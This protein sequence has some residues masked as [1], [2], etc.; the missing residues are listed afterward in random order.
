MDGLSKRIDRFRHDERGVAL[1][2]FAFALPLLILLF[3][4]VIEGARTVWSFQKAAEGV[5]ETTRYLARV[6]PTDI[7]DTAGSVAGMDDTLTA[8]VAASLTGVNI[9]PRQVRVVDVTP[10]FKCVSA[11]TPLRVDPTPVAQVRAQVQIRRPFAELLRWFGPHA[12]VI[13]VTFDE[14]SRI[15]GH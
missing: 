1:I 2:E 3:G 12:D 9:H 10:A 5:R 6:T 8:M 7:C 4:V 11:S 15:Y 14:E 13:T